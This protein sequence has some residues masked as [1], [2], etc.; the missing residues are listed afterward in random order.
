MPKRLFNHCF[1][2][3]YPTSVKSHI[4]KFSSNST[5]NDNDDDDDDKDTD[6]VNNDDIVKGLN[7]GVI[8]KVG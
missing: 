2:P 3:L 8:S 4:R 5:D 6:S 7:P 1:I